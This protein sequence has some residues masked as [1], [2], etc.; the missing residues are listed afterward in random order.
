M[1]VGSV[2][3]G[4]VRVGSVRVGY[5]CMGSMDAPPTGIKSFFFSGDWILLG[6]SV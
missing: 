6:S 3:V 4:S 5:V 1:R 2:R